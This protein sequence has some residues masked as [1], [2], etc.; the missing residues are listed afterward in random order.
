MGS[1]HANLS[2]RQ[3]EP[4]ILVWWSNLLFPLL[5]FFFFSFQLSW[6]EC[7][8][9]PHQPLEQILLSFL[10]ILFDK[11]NKSNYSTWTSKIRLWLSSLGY[12][13][14]LTIMIESIPTKN[15]EQWIKIDTQLSSVIKFIIHTSNLVFLSMRC[16]HQFGVRPMPII[17]ITQHLY[18]VCQN[19]LTLLAQRNFEGLISTSFGR[20]HAALHDFSYLLPRYV[21]MKKELKNR[22]TFFMTFDLY[23]LPQEYTATCHKILGLPIHPIDFRIIWAPPCSSKNK[24]ETH[25]SSVGD[26]NTVALRSNNY[27]R[28]RKRSSKIVQ[29][30]NIATALDMYNW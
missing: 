2:N 29:N 20:I 28:S 8:P 14:H 23:G 16:V 1:H 13:S 22:S 21:D 6:K 25:T 18:G 12:K 26:N 5:R 9:T 11:M 19:P 15:W 10:T 17:P 3:C 24:Q 4:P 27:G 30:V 7:L